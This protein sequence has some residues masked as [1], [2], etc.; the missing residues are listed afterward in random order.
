MSASKRCGAPFTSASTPVTAVPAALVSSFV[1]RA[2]RSSV[3]FGCSS[4]GR[5]A[6]T[7]ASDLA[8]TRQ[9]KPSQVW[10]R[11]Q[12]LYGH[13]GLVQHHRGGRGERVVA[14]GL[15]IVEQFL[16]ARLAG[17]RRRRI[18][19]AGR[20]LGGIDAVL[21]VHLIEL[22]GLGVIGLEFVVADRPGRRDAVVMLQLA[23][24]LLAQA[25][26]RRAEH[27]CRAADEI[28]H[29]R[30]ERLAVGQQPGIW[31]DVAV[32]GEDARRRSSCCA[33]RGSQSPRSRIRIFLPDGASRCA[34]VPPPAPLPMMMT[35]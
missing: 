7:S 30:L 4:A 14:G 8:C 1:A 12:R 34:S 23:E 9:G 33:S 10:Q 19:R 32:V 18:G 2:L 21:A 22:L 11:M 25:I 31:R 26:Q 35:S 13:V 5:T 29:L 24:I 17:D 16:D 27:L 6:I 3:T 15:E 28:V 20:R